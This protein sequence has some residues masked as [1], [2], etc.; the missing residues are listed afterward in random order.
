MPKPED[1]GIKTADDW[2]GY[3]N[4]RSTWSMIEAY[5]RAL[6]T[7]ERVAASFK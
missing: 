4:G 2:S 6:E 3:A 1:F 7:W 5:K